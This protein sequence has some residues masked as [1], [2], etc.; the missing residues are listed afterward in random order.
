MGIAYRSLIFNAD[1]RATLNCIINFECFSISRKKRSLTMGGCCN[2]NEAPSDA[3]LLDTETYSKK[4]N[5]RETHAGEYR[6]STTR[7]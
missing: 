6:S 7:S 3:R 1:P 2:S 4:R 5:K